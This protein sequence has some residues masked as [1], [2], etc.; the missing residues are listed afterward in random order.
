MMEDNLMINKQ[1][2]VV[3]A[4]ILSLG[5]VSQAFALDTGSYS[6]ELISARSLGQGNTGVAGVSDDPVV[7]YRNPA[8]LTALPGTQAMVN[9]TYA[10]SRPTYTE[11]TDQ[12]PGQTGNVIGARAT[13]VLVP[14]IAAS[15]L[16]M[17]GRLGFGVST[18]VPYGSETHF[19]G[20]SPLRYIATDTQLKV[21]IVSPAIAYKINDQFSFG[22]GADYANI[23][24]GALNRKLDTAALNTVLSGGFITTGSDTNSQLAGNGDGWGYH[25]GA[26]YKPNEEN[27]I[28][29]V[30]HSNIKI[31][32]NGYLQLTGLNGP[33][34][35]VFG[36]QN[37]TTNVSAPVYLPENIQLGYAFMPNKKW[38]FEVDAAWYDWY[39]ARQLGVVFKDVS[40]QSTQGQVLASGNPEQFNTRNTLNFGAGVNYKYDDKLQLRS[41]AFYEGAS[42]AESGFNPGFIDLPRYGLGCGFGYAL[43]STVGL[44]FAYEY[45]FYHTR[46]ISNNLGLINTG[47]ASNNINGAFDNNSQTVSLSLTVRLP[48]WSKS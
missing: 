9:L 15:T 33:A 24:E 38:T 20:D 35:T 39:A 10:N 4:A 29:L 23:V 3:A 30:Y 25:L 11:N 14:G 47:V 5:I 6:V 28:G 37:F 1:V 8:A 45:V 40:S 27:S 42:E 18:V 12:I 36:G 7:S 17:D 2:R 43:T 34:A 32:L 21:V 48:G 16:L 13:S 44:D 46:Y 41:G 19:N 22:V 26:T 31:W